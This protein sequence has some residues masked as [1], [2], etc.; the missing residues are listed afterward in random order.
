[1]LWQKSFGGT[2]IDY[3][4]AATP[5]NDNSI[6]AVGESESSDGDVIENKGFTDVL[7]IKMN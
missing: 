1:M 5:L 4:Y 7:I 3:T 6:I 2:N